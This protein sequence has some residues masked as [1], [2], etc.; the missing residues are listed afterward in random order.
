MLH[1][2]GSGS[3]ATTALVRPQA[4]ALFLL[5]NVTPSWTC[6]RDKTVLRPATFFFLPPRYMTVTVS[7]G[8]PSYLALPLDALFPFTSTGSP[9]HYSMTL[10][11]H[12]ARRISVCHGKFPFSLLVDP[13][14]PR[15]FLGRLII[16]CGLGV[17]IAQKKAPFFLRASFPLRKCRLCC[18]FHDDHAPVGTKTPLIVDLRVFTAS[19]FFGASLSHRLAS[20]SS[21]SS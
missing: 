9:G 15:L 3:C 13:V 12:A 19:A 17:P 16:C 6:P 8:R 14:I 10:L 20:N 18:L 1:P 11:F 2:L 5:R 7:A 4:A 21:A